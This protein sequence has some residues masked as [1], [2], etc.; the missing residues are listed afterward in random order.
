MLVR[1]IISNLD[2]RFPLANAAAWDPV[3]LQI[4]G[5]D[6]PSS[7]IGVCHEPNEHA[8]AAAIDAGLDALVSYHPLL[9]T[10]TTSFVE[11]P[12]AEGRAVRLAEEGVSLI[13]VH[14]ALDAANP[15]TGDF[16]LESLGLT[17]TARWGAEDGDPVKAIGRLAEV[18]TPVSAGDFVDLVATATGSNV[19]ATGG[20]AEIAAVAVLPGSGASF[21]TEAIDLADVLITGDVSHHRARDA[22]DLGLM[23]I[24]I[25]HTTTELAG[26]QA[27]YAAVCEFAPE[28]VFVGDDPTPW[29]REG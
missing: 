26:I 8:V 10:P 9:F 18:D 14:T 12:T 15:G 22:A 28:T 20:P 24:D 16:F 23:V 11:G 29:L 3:G 17:T 13:V 5:L 2:D 7:A 6:R 4:G 1:D 27:L 19:R 21:I 25:G